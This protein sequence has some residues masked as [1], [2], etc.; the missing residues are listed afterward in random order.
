MA[1]DTYQ[2][3]VMKMYFILPALVMYM[4]VARCIIPLVTIPFLDFVMIH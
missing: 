3:V 2:G 4:F 1:I